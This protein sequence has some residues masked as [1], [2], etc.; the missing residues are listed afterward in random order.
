[1]AADAHYYTT[2]RAAPVNGIN[3]KRLRAL[4]L[5]GKL[6]PCYPGEFGRRQKSFITD[7]AG[8]G[9]Y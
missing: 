3:L 9:L 2:P 7:V 6:A 4:I 1:V 5:T 8:G